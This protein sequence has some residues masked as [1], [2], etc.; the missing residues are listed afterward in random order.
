MGGLLIKWIGLIMNNLFI[1]KR[2]INREMGNYTPNSF[3]T[4]PAHLPPQWEQRENIRTLTARHKIR[5]YN[6]DSEL[7]VG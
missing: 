6:R 3:M 4:Q 5:N 1:Y 2:V 7:V